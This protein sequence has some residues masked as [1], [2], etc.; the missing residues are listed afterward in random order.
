MQFHHE[1]TYNLVISFFPLKYK[2]VRCRDS[3]VFHI[4]PLFYHKKGTNNP[5][6]EQRGTVLAKKPQ[7]DDRGWERSDVVTHRQ[8]IALPLGEGQSESRLPLAGRN[9][10]H[11]DLCD[12]NVLR[13]PGGTPFGV[14]LG[15]SGN[16][17]EEAR[18]LKQESIPYHSRVGDRCA[19]HS[20][21]TNSKEKGSKK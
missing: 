10:I 6:Q 8:P 9:S 1:I 2:E 12:P 19:W 11:Y 3:G 20:L 7:C 4:S 13:C 15:K 18:L 14:G 5:C 16:S 17:I 21:G